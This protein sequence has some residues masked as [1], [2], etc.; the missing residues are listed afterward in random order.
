MAKITGSRNI[1]IHIGIVVFFIIVAYAY[2]SPLLEGKALEQS[3]ITHF[4]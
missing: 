4:K 2:L 3:D 1:L